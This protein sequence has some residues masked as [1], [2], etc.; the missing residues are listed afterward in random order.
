M[1]GLVSISVSMLAAAACHIPNPA[2]ETSDGEPADAGSDPS[3]TT[4][5]QSEGEAEGSGGEPMCM[6]HPDLELAIRVMG[7]DGIRIMPDCATGQPLELP[8]SANYYPGNDNIVEHCPIETCTCD[9]M[10]C[11]CNDCECPDQAKTIIHL[12]DHPVLMDGG[13]GLPGCGHIT[14][15]PRAR[16]EGCEWGGLL[17]YRGTSQLPDVIASN[18]LDVPPLTLT[19]T[20][21]LTL[22]DHESCPGF[23]ACPNTLPPPGRHQLDV[24]GRIISVEESPP[25]VAVFG[26]VVQFAVDNRMSSVT[27]DCQ[28]RVS[29]LAQ[30]W[31]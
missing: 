18:T 2:Y 5:G 19:E 26:N 3:D 1:R 21:T 9:P 25:L 27:T 22:R 16:P 15:W 6:L 11:T 30:R 12:G 24:M 31:Q 8:V 17:L 28:P 20:L 4:V 13:V 7:P 14:L 10:T 23:D 29:W